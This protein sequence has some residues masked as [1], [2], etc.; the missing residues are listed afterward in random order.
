MHE[1]LLQ[2]I[3]QYQ[4][5]N[6]Q[7]LMLNTGETLQVISA[8]EFNS[9][10]GPDFANARIKIGTTAWA[11]NIEVHVKA[12]E[13]FNHGHETDDRYSNIILHVVWNDDR[14]I[15]DKFNNLVPTLELKQRVSK[16]LL[17]Q[18]DHWM[19]S[20]EHIPCGKQLQQLSALVWQNWK[21]RLLAERL[22][23][24]TKAILQHV[25]QTGNHW[26]EVLWRM[27]CRYFGGHINAASFEQLA[28]SV[29]VK[30]LAKNKNQIH[31]L[32]AMLLGQA[33]LLNQHFKEDYPRMLSR[34]YLFCKAKY[35]LGQHLVVPPAFLRMRPGNF[36]T[37]RLAQLAMLI[38]SSGPLFS[39]ILETAD[40]NDIKKIFNITANDYW[41][42]HF[43]LD[44][45]TAFQPKTLGSQM[46]DTVIINTVVPVLFT[47]GFYS[48]DHAAKEKAIRWL[49]EL[50]T[51]KNSH[52]KLYTAL[53]IKPKNA[54]DSQALLQLKK[55]YCDL[56]R[57][58]ECAAGN[59]ILKRS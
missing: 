48:D 57:C 6:K 46:I 28:V 35:Q 31:Q 9:N 27:L 21:E 37:V 24:K 22:M 8:G 39:V 32:E 51:E 13:W 1:R 34:E 4:Y 59:A 29:P 43:R 56:K 15:L 16:L 10:Q 38:H 36:P 41:H 26:E 44:E 14:F 54:F 33:G 3:W 17:E 11:G 52:T 2:Y 45:K 55:N 42:Y 53:G 30:I 7:S 19:H 25:E 40:I 50:E 23:Q 58:L 12:S 47:Y 49:E 20:P 5:F 18:Y